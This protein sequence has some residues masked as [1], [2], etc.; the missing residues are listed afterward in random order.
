MR[1][2]LDRVGRTTI[3]TRETITTVAG[4]PILTAEVTIVARD[5]NT[6][7]PRALSTEER[8]AVAR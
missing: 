2:G 3:R 4:A 1:C 5:A 7:R 8:E 6:G